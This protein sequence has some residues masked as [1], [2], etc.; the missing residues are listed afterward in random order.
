MDAK[1]DVEKRCEK[2][3][4]TWP[5]ARILVLLAAFWTAQ[6]ASGAARKDLKIDPKRPQE[7]SKTEDRALCD[8][9][10]RSRALLCD[11]VRI[12]LI[13]DRFLIDFSLNL[14]RC[15]FVFAWLSL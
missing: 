11:F 13:F 10:G 6:G 7:L 14:A 12:L 1:S 4:K 8:A 15:W 5:R 3:R 9:F 2:M